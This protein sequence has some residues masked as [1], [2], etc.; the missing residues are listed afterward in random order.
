MTRTRFPP[1]PELSIPDAHGLTWSIPNY[2]VDW[3]H[4]LMLR[5]VGGPDMHFGAILSSFDTL[6]GES[7]DLLEL[8]L[9]VENVGDDL[10]VTI[11]SGWWQA[12]AALHPLGKAALYAS[13]CKS[14]IW[15]RCWRSLATGS[16]IRVFGLPETIEGPWLEDH[17]TIGDAPRAELASCAKSVL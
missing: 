9:N 4:H 12:E 10:E 3:N 17:W 11:Q 15:L 2:L 6:P 8:H 5:E 16:M 14:L 1:H 7:T 13:I